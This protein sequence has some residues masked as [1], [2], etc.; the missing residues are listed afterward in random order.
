MAIRRFK[1]SG[2]K[3]PS[4]RGLMVAL[5]L[6]GA[7]GAGLLAV[8]EP[9]GRRTVP[10]LAMEKGPAPVSSM[11]AAPGAPATAGMSAAAAAPGVSGGPA[12]AAVTGTGA[13]PATGPAVVPSFDVVR[14]SPA[15][16]AVIAGR[17]AAGS[18]V[19]VFDGDRVVARATADRRGEFVALPAAP[20]PAGGRELTLASRA[21][22]G[23]AELRGDQ[24]VV[25]MVPVAPRAGAAPAE[26]PT[27]ALLDAHG[28]ARVLQDAGKRAQPLSLDIVDYDEKGA[29]RFSGRAA[30]GSAVRVYVDNGAVGDARADE[31]GRWGLAPA[32]A[33]A[34]GVHS[35]RADTVDGGGRVVSRVELPFQRESVASVAVEPSERGVAGSRIVVQP[36]E[37]LWR[38]ARAAYGSGTRYT[39]IF[40]ANQAQIR[41]PGLIYPGQ[42]F[43]VP[44]VR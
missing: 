33:I 25:V 24:S 20:L 41:D 12:V 40:Q 17:A 11:A 44:L 8:W 9:G 31:S 15:G 14:V 13:A 6:I 32:G 4:S 22:Q 26:A 39:V 2:S 10:R 28:G 35:L 19:V 29:V 23:G 43:A 37:T 3:M 38:L 36:G 27:V 16:N 7:L 18:E 42:A 21:P 5:V 1:M 30:A 34:A